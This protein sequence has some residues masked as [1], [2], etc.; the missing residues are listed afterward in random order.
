MKKLTTLLLSLMAISYSWGQRTPSHPVDIKDVGT[1][2]HAIIDAWEPGTA[3]GAVTEM[4]EQFYI[5]RVRLMSRIEDGDYRIH[6]T[7][8]PDC[9][10]FM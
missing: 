9:K 4:D 8:S 2:L 1:S 5:S 7:V 6:E 3:P 10:L